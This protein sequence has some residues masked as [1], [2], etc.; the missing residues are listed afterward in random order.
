VFDFHHVKLVLSSF[1]IVIKPIAIKEDCSK[2]LIYGKT[3]LKDFVN[4]PIIVNFMSFSIDCPH[5]NSTISSFHKR[6]KSFKS[7]L[8]ESETIDV[9]ATIASNFY[10][11][12]S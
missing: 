11:S 2:F 6:M 9:V 5:H 1:V 4:A 3:K 7:S 10:Q 8:M 12:V